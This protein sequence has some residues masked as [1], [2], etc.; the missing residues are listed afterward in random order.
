MRAFD[1][2]WITTLGP[3]VDAFE[4]EVCA[5]HRRPLCCG[6]QFVHRGAAPGAGARRGRAQVTRCG[7]RHSPS[8][9]PQTPS[10]TSGR[11]SGSS[12][13][14]VRPG[15]WI[16]ICSAAELARGRRG[17]P[18]AKGGRSA[19]DLYGQCAQLDRIAEVV[20]PATGSTLDRG[21]GGGARRHLEVT[22]TP[23]RSGA[24]G[25]F[26]FNG[27]KIMTTSGGGMLVGS[28]RGHGPCKYLALSRPDSRCLTTSTIEVG[29]NYRLSNILAA[30]GRAPTR[31]AAA[32]HRS[33]PRDQRHATGPVSPTIEGIDF[34][35]WDER[36]KHQRLAH[37]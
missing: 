25:V 18:P 37:A 30:M 2:N 10:A 16:R 33:L 28:R 12:I 36:G 9:L 7:S 23:A 14:N 20:R 1:S 3:E 31:A 35:P 21:R 29:Y 13:P 22:G 11:S 4:A 5:L 34:M 24:F 19:V 8:L 6:V 17:E 32:D 27:N 26:S 15:T